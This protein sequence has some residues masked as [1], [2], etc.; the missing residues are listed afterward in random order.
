[1]VIHERNQAGEKGETTDKGKK[2]AAPAWG[3]LEKDI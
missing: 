3:E 1:M 2:Q